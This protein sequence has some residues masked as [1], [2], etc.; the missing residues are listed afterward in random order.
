[1]Q[2]IL[3]LTMLTNTILLLTDYVLHTLSIQ[4]ILWLTVLTNTILLLTDYV[5]HAGKRHA[6]G[7]HNTALLRQRSAIVN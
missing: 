2:A 7:V 4:A 5:L 6:L 1:M 3:P